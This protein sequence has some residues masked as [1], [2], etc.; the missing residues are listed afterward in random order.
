MTPHR[1]FL[2]LL[3]LTLPF[4]LGAC[5]MFDWATQN[6]PVIGQRCENWQCFTE[7]G[8]QQSQLNAQ[9]RQHPADNPAAGGTAAPG[10]AGGAPSPAAAPAEPLTPAMPEEGAYKYVPRAPA[11]PG[12]TPFDGQ[13][14]P[15]Q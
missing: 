12:T 9:Q 4:A 11:A 1:I 5:G 8:Q 3:A 13:I 7:G 6:M 10:T 15:V 2:R 14:P